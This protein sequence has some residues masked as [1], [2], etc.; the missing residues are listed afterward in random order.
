VQAFVFPL[1]KVFW[2]VDDFSLGFAFELC[3]VVWAAGYAQSAAYAFLFVD[4]CYVVL[5]GYCVYLAPGS[6]GSAVEALSCVDCGRVVGVG[7][8][9][10][11][12]PFVDASEYAAA[13]AATVADVA[14]T[15]HH[16][17]DSVD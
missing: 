2:R 5:F 3:S 17:A 4:D 11:Y 16:V 12:A 6:A 1:G 15:F 13:A 10:F 8:T 14:Y 9:V 7:Y